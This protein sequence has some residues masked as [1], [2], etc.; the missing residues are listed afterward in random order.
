MHFSSF[1][2]SS[3]LESSV[4][5][6]RSTALTRTLAGVCATGTSSGIC[7]YRSHNATATAAE[8]SSAVTQAIAIN[9]FV[10]LRNIHLSIPFPSA[11]STISNA[12]PRSSPA[13]P[14]AATSTN[15]CLM[16]ASCECV[17]H[18]ISCCGKSRIQ[19]TT[20]SAQPPNP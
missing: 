3:L 5:T 10:V 13:K 12:I 7:C 20:L 18:L 11:Q 14:S 2:T 9:R 6:F 16:T 15:H 1:A 17:K 4:S 8:T 19:K